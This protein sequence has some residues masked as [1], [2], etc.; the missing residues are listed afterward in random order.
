M[1]SLRTATDADLPL[2]F[3]WRNQPE[4]YEG[5]YSQK[6]PLTW[7]EHRNWWYSRPSSWK[8]FIVYNDEIPIGVINLGQL[9]HWSPEIGWYI[10]EIDEWGK[11]YGTEAVR[12]ALLWLKEQGYE[13]CHTTIKW[14]NNRSIRLAW[15]LGF[16]SLCA[17]R[18][19]E[20]WLTNDL[21]TNFR[22]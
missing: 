13:Y 11:G 19:G 8:T 17:A 15:N 21:K 16:E 5:F 14:D 12:Q 4:V 10:G 1:I 9:E 6:E 7:G 3:K 2:M 18:E 22:L 20:M